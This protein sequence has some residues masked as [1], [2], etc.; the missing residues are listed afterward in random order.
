[1]LGAA[2]FGADGDSLA[3]AALAELAA[4]ERQVAVR[5]SGTRG[6]LAGKLAD[7]DNGRGVFRGSQLLHTLAWG[8]DL[9]TEAARLARACL[10]WN[11]ADL[12]LA[13]LVVSQDGQ[14]EVGLGVADGVARRFKTIQRGFGGHPDYAR[15]WSA[16]VCLDL[17][18]RWDPTRAEP[19]R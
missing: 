10:G 6:W 18:R 1:A 7:A 5:E 12:G 13:V 19:F 14:I 3:E 2:I 4:S 8:A 9:E 17:L 11:D 15:E 16:N